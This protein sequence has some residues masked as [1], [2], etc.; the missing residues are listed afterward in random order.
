MTKLIVFDKDG[1]LVEPIS[2]GTFVSQP[3][4][5]R[6]RPGVAQKL[7]QL[8]S[9][10][11]QMAIASNQGG[12][13]S[14][15]LPV[16]DI[17]VGSWIRLPSLNGQLEQFKVTSVGSDIDGSI[18]FVLDRER[19]TGNCY[20][21]LHTK[22]FALVAFKSIDEAIEEMKFAAELCGI[23]YCLFCPAMDG[24]VLWIVANHGD[25]WAEL[26][27]HEKDNILGIGNF[28]KPNPGMLN[29][30]VVNTEIGLSTLMVGDRPE[31][32][33]AAKAAGFAFEWANDF[34]GG[35]N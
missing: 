13:A 6:L 4:D 12:C 29:T 33:A 22:D 19:W 34:F 28:R 14:H 2:G 27:C 5:Q 16:A 15:Q 21:C 24:S 8:K 32:Q 3:K 31:D 17:Q 11:A 30:I 7:A 25:G 10:G 18:Y 9:E 26:E 23:D 1:T 35:G 20:V